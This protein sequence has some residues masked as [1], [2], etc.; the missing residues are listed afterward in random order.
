[1]CKSLNVSR[2]AFYTWERKQSLPVKKKRKTLLK[3]KI[4]QIHEDSFEIYGRD[5][6]RVELAKEGEEIS[7]TYTG[8]L[9]QELGIQSVLRKKFVV[10]TDSAHDY[11][12]PG[13]I[14]N[15]GFKIDVLGKVWVSDITYI[16]MGEKWVYLTVIIDLADRKVV[17][18][19][20]S[21]DMTTENTVLKAWTQ[22]RNNRGIIEGF[23]LHSDRGSQY[24]SGI[25]RQIFSCLQGARQSMSRKGNCWDNAVAE[26]FFKSAKYEMLNRYKFEN[27]DQVRRAVAHYVHWYNTKRLHSALGQK[28]PTEK[29]AE[30]LNILNQAA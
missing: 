20:L 14:L 28:S 16:R 15:R 17:G 23:L 5:R 4:K 11:P 27:M 13:N 26:S 29:E 30:L 21:E 1:M 18:Y 2:N 24:A 25:M 12:V 7:R 6:I 9:M 19:S 10:T 22:A 3:N 8:R